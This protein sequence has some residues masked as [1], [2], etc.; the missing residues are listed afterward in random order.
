VDVYG[1]LKSKSTLAGQ[2]TAPPSEK[3]FD[4]HFIVKLDPAVAA[5]SPYYDPSY[6]VNYLNAADFEAKAVKGYADDFGDGPGIYRF[7]L[8]GGPVGVTLVP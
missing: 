2:N 6:G 3:V 4:A 5:A 7:R 8:R 1:D